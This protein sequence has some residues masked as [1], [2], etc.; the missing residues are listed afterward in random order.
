VVAGYHLTSTTS[1]FGATREEAWD[2]QNHGLPYLDVGRGILVE[3]ALRGGTNSHDGKSGTN[4]YLHFSIAAHYCGAEQ[5]IIETWFV[6]S[7][8]LR[9]GQKCRHCATWAPNLV[10]DKISINGVFFPRRLVHQ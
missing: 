6:D 3:G 1:L 4:F 7:V 8:Y 10:N 5:V 2:H 9:G